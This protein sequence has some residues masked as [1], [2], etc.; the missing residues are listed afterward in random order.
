MA[1]L[2][3]LT[4]QEDNPAATPDIETGEVTKLREAFQ[5]RLVIANL[6][7]EAV[8][9]GMVDLDGLKMID[10]AS[11]RLGDDD[12]VIGGRKMMDDLRRSKPWL[13]GVASSSSAAAVPATQPVRQKTALEMTE[14]EYVAARSAVTKYQF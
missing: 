2:L 8:R 13:F 14:E 12:T 9:A 1:D 4:D 11:V 6:R 10:V 5:S 7:T 3:T